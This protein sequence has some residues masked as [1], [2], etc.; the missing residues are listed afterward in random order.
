MYD[1]RHKVRLDSDL[2]SHIGL[3]TTIQPL[4]QLRSQLHFC[5]I[6]VCHSLNVLDS[7]QRVKPYWELILDYVP[8]DGNRYKAS[9]ASESRSP[10]TR[11]VAWREGEP[12]VRY[13]VEASKR[14]TRISPQRDHST[15][16]G[17]LVSLP[18]WIL[19]VVGSYGDGSLHS[20]Y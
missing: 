7:I 11:T 13:L 17:R 5:F 6:S 20:L 14:R 4:V 18:N 15:E 8:R 3:T 16:H 10:S 1:H 9:D 12:V 2:P 19:R